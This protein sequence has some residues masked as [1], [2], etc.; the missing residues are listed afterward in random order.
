VIFTAIYRAE[1]MFKDRQIYRQLLIFLVIFTS[2]YRARERWGC[3]SS[4]KEIAMKC[5]EIYIKMACYE[6]YSCFHQ[7]MHQQ[8][9]LQPIHGKPK[10]TLFFSQPTKWWFLKRRQLEYLHHARYQV[11]SE[12]IT[13]LRFQVPVDIRYQLIEALWKALLLVH[14]L[15]KKMH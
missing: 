13:I 4:G 1:R 2:I 14:N 15:N 10:D 12:S 6:I 5:Y 8:Y 7:H 9:H 3:R 11:L